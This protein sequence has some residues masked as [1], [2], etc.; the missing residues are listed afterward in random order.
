MAEA[1]LRSAM[2]LAGAMEFPHATLKLP[3]HPLLT[4]H[5]VYLLGRD[6][7]FPNDKARR[8]FGF[9]PA[10]DL[11]EGIK[12]SGGLVELAIKLKIPT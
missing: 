10:V 1:P 9:S 5:A 3:G 2:L 7:E 12:R 4:R 6:Q 8:D 11:T